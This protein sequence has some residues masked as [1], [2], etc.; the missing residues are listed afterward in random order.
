MVVRPLP[1]EFSRLQKDEVKPAAACTS[2][3]GA[4]ARTKRRKERFT[5]SDTVG[6]TSKESGQERSPQ[7][8]LET[9]ND[10]YI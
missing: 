3:S 5:V 10:I 6:G 1:L 8:V 2:T 7:E 9:R 4:K